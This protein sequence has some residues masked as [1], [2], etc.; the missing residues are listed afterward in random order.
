MFTGVGPRCPSITEH[1]AP[2]TIQAVQCLCHPLL[3][4]RAQLWAL[5]PLQKLCDVSRGDRVVA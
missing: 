4:Q 2:A 1:L 5:R 3:S